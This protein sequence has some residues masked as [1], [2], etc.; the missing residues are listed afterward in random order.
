MTSGLTG[1][2]VRVTGASSRSFIPRGERAVDMAFLVVL[3]VLALLG[4]HQIFTGWQ[5]LL[6]GVAGLLLGLAVTQLAWSR[7]WPVVAAILLGLA[8]FALLAG[9]LCLRSTGDYLPGKEL[10][11][12]VILGW[13]ELVTT[14]PPADGSGPLLVLPWLLGTTTGVVGGLL[15]G[16]PDR[17][18]APVRLALPLLA[19]VALLVVVVLLGIRE[20]SSLLLQ[21][22]LFAVIALAW[23]VARGLAR[24]INV[25]GARTGSLRRFG[26][27]AAMVVVATGLAI[28]LAGVGASDDQRTVLRQ[29]VVP[30]VDIAQY[31]SPLSAFRRY[32]PKTEPA[33]LNLADTTLMTISGADGER[34]RFATLDRYDGTVWTAS[35]EPAHALPGTRAN[36]FLRVSDQIHNPTEG[37]KVKAEVEL[38]E[39]WSGVW[40]PTIGALQTIDF[41]DDQDL[42]DHFRYNLATSTG[43]VEGGL[44]EGDHYRFTAVVPQGKLTPET[45]ASPDV[46][47]EVQA[48]AAFLQE[49]AVELGKGARTPMGQVLQIADR[50]KQKGYYSDGVGKADRSITAGHYQKRLGL[51]FLD[52]D[53][54][55]GD[56]EQY[57][58][59]MALLAN[60]VGVPARVVIGVDKVP[61]GGRITGRQVHAWVELEAADGSWRT[62]PRSAFM[63][64][65]DAPAEQPPQQRQQSS[66]SEVPPPNPVPPPST[67]GG[68]D[69][70]DLRAT[71]DANGDQGSFAIPAWLKVTLISA[72]TPVLLLGLFAALVLGAKAVRRTR[73]RRAEHPATRVV[74]AWRELVDHARDLGHGIPIRGTTRREQASKVEEGAG[75]VAATGLARHADGHV[76]GPTGPT[77]EEAAAYWEEIERARADLSRRH[78]RWQRIKGALSLQTFWRRWSPEPTTRRSRRT[79]R[80]AGE[81]PV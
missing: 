51:D 62:L 77:D 47:P 13:K 27:G 30:P 71:K 4:L 31:G 41:G 74:G 70:R 46:D 37:R 79:R 20:P 6:V 63:R 39:G 40:L 23:L 5:Y 33:S 81:L 2:T 11:D 36:A 8:V 45:A 68:Q 64:Q 78:D 15:I 57:A 1:G 35:E 48:A 52:A 67:L 55:Q 76:F 59:A 24:T 75:L 17:V 65:E 61:D 42:K 56:D 54:M 32:R 28:P 22:V 29:Q 69:E 25:A 19:P 12:T 60:R 34:V 18:P 50:M 21:G 73:R 10:L 26:L 66:G 44:G 16:L 7:R 80:D 38:G 9:P 43:I 3:S 14:L 53:V 58:A 49:S 72:G